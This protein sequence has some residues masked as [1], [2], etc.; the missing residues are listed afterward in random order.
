MGEAHDH[1]AGTDD[2]ARLGKCFHHDAIG[3]GQQF[4]VAAGVQRCGGLRFGRPELGAGGI[5]GRLDLFM[6]QGRNGTRSLQVPVALLLVAGLLGPCPGG[7]DGLLLGMGGQ[8]QVHR[9]EAQQCLAA[10]DRLA[11]IHQALEHL[12]GHAKSK[13]ALHPG[14]DG[15]G[16]DALGRMAWRYQGGANEGWLGARIWRRAFAAGCECK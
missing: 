9:V 4:G 12:A 1:L 11:C 14:R 8:L 13:I 16:E 7:C 10:P 2:L 15:A 5:R 6:G 3:I